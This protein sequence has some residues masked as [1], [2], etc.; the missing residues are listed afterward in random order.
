MAT[1]DIAAREAELDAL[2]AKVVRFREG[3]VLV[4]DQDVE[5]VT[6]HASEVPDVIPHFD[7][8]VRRNGLNV[9]TH[10]S[11]LAEVVPQNCIDN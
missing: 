5:G 10:I 4:I 9:W 1:Q 2:Y 6:V 8:L 7:V 3:G 11:N